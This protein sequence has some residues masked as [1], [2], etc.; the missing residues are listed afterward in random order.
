MYRGATVSSYVST[1][2]GAQ[3]DHR[4]LSSHVIHL[5]LMLISC[6]LIVGQ[7]YL[8]PLGLGDLS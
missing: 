6:L 1:S 2:Y 7:Q 8:E 4:I 3:F 5:P